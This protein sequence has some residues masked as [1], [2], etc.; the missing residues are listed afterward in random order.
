MKEPRSSYGH[1]HYRSM[2]LVD[3]LA[4]T[5]DKA[6]AKELSNACDHSLLNLQRMKEHQLL[7]VRGVG[8][9]TAHKIMALCELLRRREVESPKRA[10]TI[11]CSRDL[12]VAF[13]PYFEGLM[14]EEF[15][16]AYL[17]RGNRI[18]SVERHSQG[19]VS[20]TVCDIKT[21]MQPAVAYTASA[22]A[23]AHNHP[24]G[25]LRPSNADRLLT[26]KVV[27][28]GKHLDIYIIDHIIITETGYFSFADDGIL[29]S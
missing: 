29:N 28:A 1:D 8:Q 11:T 13:R 23:L 4:L 17:N 5:F 12:Y 7:A 3:L 24:S 20:G 18:I 14:V 15:W 10:K 27:S 19:G 16:V 26:T 2:A 6:T 22:I 9:S 25:N 21:I